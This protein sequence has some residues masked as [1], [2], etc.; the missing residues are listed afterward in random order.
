MHVK[1]SS[2]TAG[3]ALAATAC[4]ALGAAAT[5]NTVGAL[6]P[7]NGVATTAAG[8]VTIT[9]AASNTAT[10]GVTFA[11]FST[12]VSSAYAS[13]T[14]GVVNFEQANVTTG[15]LPNTTIGDSAA[16]SVTALYGTSLSNSL[17]FYRSDAATTP[18][19]AIDYNTNQGA[20]LASGATGGGYL[21]VQGA[22]NYSLTFSPG[23]VDFGITFLPRADA[24]KRTSQ[25]V[26][27]YSDSST[28]TSSTETTNP[29]GQSANEIFF[30]FSAPTGLT[31]SSI[32]SINPAASRFDDLAFVVSA[33][34]TTPEPA[35]LSVLALGGLGLLARRR[36]A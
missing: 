28:T 3:L 34:V 25:F 16:N 22:S 27:H 30:G 21:G 36:R 35:S 24:A 6:D 1:L 9:D 8:T 13:D 14:G 11:S 32:D 15:N 19:V 7:N 17:S 29:T 26:V 23:I 5:F 12:L 2:I 18:T 4:T 33:P 10:N 20:Y 31:I